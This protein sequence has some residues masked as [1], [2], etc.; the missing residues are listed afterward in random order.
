MVT[1]EIGDYTKYETHPW[2]APSS[3]VFQ[4][5]YPTLYMIVDEYDKQ[6]KATEGF[7]MDEQ[8]ATPIG[9]S[10][11]IFHLAEGDFLDTLIHRRE[12]NMW[13]V[14]EFQTLPPPLGGLFI[15]Q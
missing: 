9:I 14:Q 7:G 1:R 11:Y 3:Y 4:V 12:N 5:T 8:D 15:W 6:G 13:R 10:G 2:Y